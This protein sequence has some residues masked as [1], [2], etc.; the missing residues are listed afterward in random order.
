MTNINLH[1]HTMESKVTEDRYTQRQ[2]DFKG[3]LRRQQKFDIPIIDIN[4]DVHIIE[5]IGL[6]AQHLFG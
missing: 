5:P 1:F 2:Q 4:S 3:N 6:P